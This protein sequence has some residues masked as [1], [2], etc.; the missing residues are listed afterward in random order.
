MKMNITIKHIFLICQFIL[1]LYFGCEKE[2]DL[3]TLPDARAITT[4]GDTN[5]IEIMPP[6]GDFDMPVSVFVGNDQLIYVADYGRNEVVMLDAAGNVLKRR[7]ILKPMA[8]GQ[9]S[10]LDLYVTGQMI[11]PNNRDTIAAIYK[12]YLVRFDTTVFDIEV[13]ELGDTNYIPRLVSYYYNHDLE[14]APMRI[15]R[16]E[17]AKPKR[18]YVG[19]AFFSDYQEGYLVARNGPDNASVVDPDTRILWFNKNDVLY[20]ERAD[21]NTVSGGGSSIIDINQLTSITVFPGSRDYIVT[22]K[23]EGVAYGALWMLFQQTAEFYGWVPKYDPSKPEHR[24]VDFVRPYRY[25]NPTAVSIDRRRR[26]IYIIDA[27]LDSLIKF[28]RNGRYRS[29]SFGKA[30]TEPDLNSPQGVAFSTDCTL[31]IA[32]TGNKVVRRFK[33]AIQRQC[34]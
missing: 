6:W 12:I 3:S 17:P 11:A 28:D 31:Y 10:K 20:S 21:L 2:Y 29:E 33:L 8:I 30:L 34:Y 7:S 4:I 23:M 19:I 14:N 22:Q 15:V 1:I 24:V 13:N 16:R 25:V 9:N 5:Y 27:G 32:D 26:D 18:R